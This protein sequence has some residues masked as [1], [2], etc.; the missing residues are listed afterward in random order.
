MVLSQT[1]VIEDDFSIEYCKKITAERCGLNESEILIAI[2]DSSTRSTVPIAAISTNSITESRNFVKRAGFRPG[3]YIASSKISG[4]KKSPVFLNDTSSKQL[5]DLE[6]T[7]FTKYLAFTSILLFAGFLVSLASVFLEYK[8]N[9]APYNYLA[10]SRD[11][12]NKKNN[13]K[14]EFILLGEVKKISRLQLDISNFQLKD[15]NLSYIPQKPKSLRANLDSVGRFSIGRQ[16]R[17]NIKT[18][19][20]EEL[21]LGEKKLCPFNP[22]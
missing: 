7:A 18:I 6:S 16:L 17:A 22:W 14:T 4:F 3:R 11:F 20:I 5:F 10:S 21:T 1:I 15:E 2:G 9:N 19:E 13:E 12:Y 8:S